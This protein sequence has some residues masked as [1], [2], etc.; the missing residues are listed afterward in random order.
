MATL[1]LGLPQV[2]GGELVW[3]V[4]PAA[5][6]I[7][8]ITPVIAC[9]IVAGAAAQRGGSRTADAPALA[10]RPASPPREVLDDR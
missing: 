7:A 9:V 5:A 6:G 1:L 2:I 10:D 4:R 3:W 8:L